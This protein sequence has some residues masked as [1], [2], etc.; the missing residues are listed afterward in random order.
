MCPE[1]L[2]TVCAQH[3][4]R[5]LQ[6]MRLRRKITIIQ[7][8]T[9]KL[10][11]ARASCLKRPTN[12]TAQ[13]PRRSLSTSH[14]SH[15][16]VFQG[17]MVRLA[18]WRFFKAKKLLTNTHVLGNNAAYKNSNEYAGAFFIYRNM[19]LPSFILYINNID[20][21]QLHVSNLLPL[22]YTL[23]GQIIWNMA[24]QNVCS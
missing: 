24:T 19:L 1:T 7:P 12:K 15:S 5:I 4:C 17:S 22:N 2:C 11:L 10:K 20:M 3:L 13:K 6:T 8:T 14:I 21:I 23:S 18:L 16:R 9:A